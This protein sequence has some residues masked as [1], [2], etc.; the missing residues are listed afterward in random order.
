MPSA[1]KFSISANRIRVSIPRGRDPYV[2]ARLISLGV[3][4]RGQE[5][6]WISSCNFTSGSL[7]AVSGEDG[8]CRLYPLNKPIIGPQIRSV[9]EFDELT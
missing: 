6:V 7:G 9:A 3:D 5:R 8:A 1:A 2:N 4:R